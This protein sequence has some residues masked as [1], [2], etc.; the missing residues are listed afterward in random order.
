MSGRD[1]S[2]DCGDGESKQKKKKKKSYDSVNGR[3]GNARRLQSNQIEK[4]G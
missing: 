4:I 2:G 3:G 1:T